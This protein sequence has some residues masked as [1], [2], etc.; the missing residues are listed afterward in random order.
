M[1]ITDRTNI[2]RDFNLLA[3]AAET[4]AAKR[5]A[6]SHRRGSRIFGEGQHRPLFPGK[7][8]FARS[9]IS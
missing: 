1:A 8:T 4:Q 2:D 7:Q 3:T 6:A 5:N 9:S